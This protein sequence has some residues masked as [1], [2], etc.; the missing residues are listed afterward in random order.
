VTSSP[1]AMAGAE[2]ICLG[3]FADSL[4]D[5]AD[6]DKDWSIKNIGGRLWK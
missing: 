2:P 4:A 5:P 1:T 3:E 6:G